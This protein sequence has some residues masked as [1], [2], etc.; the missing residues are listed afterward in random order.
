MSGADLIAT[1]GCGCKA[2]FRD[3]VEGSPITVVIVTKSAGCLMTIHVA[4]MA[5]YDHREA[6][7]PPTRLAPPAHSDYEEN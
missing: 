4:G 1:L 5:V 3:G 6:L 7:R 2:G